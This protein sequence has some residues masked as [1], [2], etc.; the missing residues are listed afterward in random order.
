MMKIAKATL[1]AGGLLAGMGAA[2]LAEDRPAGTLN[3]AAP[4]PSADTGLTLPPEP[5]Y[6]PPIAPPV[7]EAP[8]P[9][10]P[11]ANAGGETSPEGSGPPVKVGATEFAGGEVQ[12]EPE[13]QGAGALFML[14][15][16]ATGLP[17]L[18]LEELPFSVMLGRT[19]IVASGP[20]T[21]PLSVAAPYTT[22][23]VP[24]PLPVRL[25]CAI[26]CTTIIFKKG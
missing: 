7:L 9:G 10:Q 14:A 12:E 19:G 15:N 16:V 6:G 13:M 24:S 20:R 17:T 5:Y 26:T 1:L 11:A 23:F 18:T 4:L 25:K 3:D 8:P 21:A 22:P 2:A